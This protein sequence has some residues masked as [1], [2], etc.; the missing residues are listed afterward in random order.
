MESHG[1]LVL[2]YAC[3]MAKKH[4]PLG[5]GPRFKRAIK[6]KGLNLSQIAEKLDMSESALRSWTNGHREINLDDY[7]RLCSVA[8]VDPAVV[9]FGD[10][11]DE[12]FLAIG[13]AWS[14]ADPIGRR[15]LWTAAQ[16]ILAQMTSAR[17]KGVAS[18]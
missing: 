18:S 17:T 4:T 14:K 7:L 3:S 15:V 6:A 11:V 13:E 12:Q 9:L 5:W 1:P 8:E 2:A 10:K 16:G